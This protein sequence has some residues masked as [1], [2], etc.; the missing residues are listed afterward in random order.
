MGLFTQSLTWSE[1]NKI[2]MK[3]CS[4]LKELLGCWILCLKP[5]VLNKI[6]NGFLADSSLCFREGKLS[7]WDQFKV[8]GEK[9]CCLLCPS[10][11]SNYKNTWPKITMR[12]DIG[13]PFFRGVNITMIIMIM[14]IGW[15]SAVSE[16]CQQVLLLYWWLGSRGEKESGNYTIHGT[17]KKWLRFQI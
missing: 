14:N 4:I 6:C 12:R 2:S 15:L 7:T 3:I 1:V 10:K 9:L 8:L 13:L 17:L 16:R 5:R 11:F